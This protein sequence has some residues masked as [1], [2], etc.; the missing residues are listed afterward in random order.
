VNLGKFRF[1]VVYEAQNVFANPSETLHC[2]TISRSNMVLDYSHLDNCHPNN[3]HRTSSMRT[4]ATQ[5]NCKP[6][7]LPTRITVTSD[8]FH[9]RQLPPGELATKGNCHLI[10]SQIGNCHLRHIE[11]FAFIAMKPI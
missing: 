9:Q 1:T 5:D 8:N 10:R 7:Q 6:G 2:T 4:T 11:F 3:C